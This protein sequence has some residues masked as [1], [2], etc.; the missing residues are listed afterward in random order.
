[1][2]PSQGLVARARARARTL[3]LGEKA[4]HIRSAFPELHPR[5]GL[6]MLK[7]HQTRYSSTRG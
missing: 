5:S 2:A 6:E 4:Y 3:L 1:V 7:G